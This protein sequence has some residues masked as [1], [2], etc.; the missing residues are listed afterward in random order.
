MRMRLKYYQLEIK[1]Q[2]SFIKIIIE[3]TDFDLLRKIKS[4]IDVVINK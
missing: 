1:E 3:H 2:F 4:I